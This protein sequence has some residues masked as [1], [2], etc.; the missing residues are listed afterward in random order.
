VVIF[1][2]TGESVFVFPDFWG[3]LSTILDYTE[4]PAIISSSILYI[5]FLRQ[6]FSYK[7]VWYLLFINIQWLHIFWITDE[8][9]IETFTKGVGLFIWPATIAWIA[10]GIDYLELPVIY[11]TVKRTIIEIK[12]RLAKKKREDEKTS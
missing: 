4:I 1:R 12:N 3:T 5:H 6:K 9:V 8:V 10:I 11:D 2:L 7:H